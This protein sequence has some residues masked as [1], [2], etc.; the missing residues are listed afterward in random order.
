MPSLG[1]ST[2]TKKTRTTQR[3]GATA[4]LDVM[5]EDVGG[6]EILEPLINS[7]RLQNY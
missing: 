7:K 6:R 5:R 4:V 2:G 3:N 1:I